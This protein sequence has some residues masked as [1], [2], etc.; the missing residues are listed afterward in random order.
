MFPTISCT[1]FY[2]VFPSLQCIT[3]SIR[4]LTY[5][6]LHF[7][8]RVFE[9]I[10]RITNTSEF[11]CATKPFCFFISILLSKLKTMSYR[12]RTRASFTDRYDA[13]HG[14]HASHDDDI[15]IDDCESSSSSSTLIPI[16]TPPS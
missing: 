9:I 5:I 13:D 15:E 11:F 6:Q 16:H 7:K 2:S 8:G 14:Y 10:A 12:A 3:S 1:F 4:Q